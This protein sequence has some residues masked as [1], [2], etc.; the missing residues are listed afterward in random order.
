MQTSG[1]PVPV[2][3]VIA[4]PQATTAPTTTETPAPPIASYAPPPKV[5]PKPTPSDV[6]LQENGLPIGWLAVLDPPSGRFFFVDENKT[7][8]VT[9]W[10]DPRTP[11]V[12]T[13]PEGA[14]EVP[15]M[16]QKTY[17]PP[18]P[19]PAVAPAPAVAVA[20]AATVAAPPVSLI[21]SEISISD[22]NLFVFIIKTPT[23]HHYT[24]LCTSSH[25]LLSPTYPTVRRAAHLLCPSHLY[26]TSIRRTSHDLRCPTACGSSGC[27]GSSVCCST[28]V[29]AGA[30]SAGCLHHL[31]VFSL[32]RR[33]RIGSLSLRKNRRLTFLPFTP[34]PFLFTAPSSKK[35]TQHPPPLHPSNQPTNNPHR[36]TTLRHQPRLLNSRRVHRWDRFWWAG[37]C[38]EPLLEGPGRR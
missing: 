35:Q 3:P 6:Q 37:R 15:V 22:S 38:W 11:E 25:H 21:S 24:D 27:S 36:N 26:H 5:T 1:A 13:A 9:T 12:E 28:G 17:A 19:K 10:D 29:P 2:L 20:A 34:F 7:P 33:R 32:D 30:S 23:V 16:P 18:P 8:P 31:W 14:P 4:P